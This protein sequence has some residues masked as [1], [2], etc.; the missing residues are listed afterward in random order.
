MRTLKDEAYVV[1]SKPIQAF[2]CEQSQVLAIDE[3]LSL[4][5]PQNATQK[6]QKGCLAAARITQ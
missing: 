5:W 4:I 3:H 6:M 2:S 1:S